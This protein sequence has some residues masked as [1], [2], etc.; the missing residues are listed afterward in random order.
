MTTL[1][2]DSLDILSNISFVALKHLGYYV[3]GTV[4]DL[5]TV[6]EGGQEYGGGLWF[7]FCHSLKERLHTLPQSHPAYIE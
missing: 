2:E 6:V 3:P 4:T 7:T 5:K 1:L